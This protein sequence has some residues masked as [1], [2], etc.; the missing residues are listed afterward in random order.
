MP[1]RLPL[2]R[3][4]PPEQVLRRAVFVDEVG[5]IPFVGTEAAARYLALTSHTLECYRAVGGGPAF[6]KFGKFVRYAVADLE[7][8]AAEHRHERTAGGNARMY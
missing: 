5:K 4:W 3:C 6:Y 1:E 8:W 7:A 2:E